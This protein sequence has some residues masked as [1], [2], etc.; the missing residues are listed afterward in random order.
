MQKQAGFSLIEV[1]IVVA[2]IG[3]LG[4][5]VFQAYQKQ[6]DESRRADAQTSLLDIAGRL[7]RCY[8]ELHSYEDC[9]SGSS[10]V[11]TFPRDSDDGH[12]E[13]SAELD[14]STF[15]LTARP[16]ELQATRDA[17]NCSALTLTQTGR[18]GAEGDQADDCWR[19]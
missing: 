12:Y 10:A 7:E 18:K 3:I 14:R 4:G 16:Q 1:I 9:G 11:V 5:I 6:V 17:D 19:D 13:I 8:S 15:T 2:I